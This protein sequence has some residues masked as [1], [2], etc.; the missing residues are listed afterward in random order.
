[1]LTQ[2]SQLE[3]IDKCENPDRAPSFT[4][5]NKDLESSIKATANEIDYIKKVYDQTGWPER[6]SDNQ[7]KQHAIL[8][9]E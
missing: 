5:T 9:Q 1:M 3:D 4:P 6:S 2:L 8:E 7:V